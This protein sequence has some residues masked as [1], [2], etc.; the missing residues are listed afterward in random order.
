MGQTRL[1]L[2]CNGGDE[3]DII[4]I[5]LKHPN[6][7]NSLSIHHKG[8]ITYFMLKHLQAIH[9]QILNIFRYALSADEEES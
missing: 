4:T 6:G 5:E 2:K 8:I 3:A 1:E 9:I 7:S